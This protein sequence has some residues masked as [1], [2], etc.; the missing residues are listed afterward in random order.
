[1]NYDLNYAAEIPL[2]ASVCLNLV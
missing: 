1:M 2:T